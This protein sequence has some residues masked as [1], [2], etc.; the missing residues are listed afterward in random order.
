MLTW[1]NDNARDGQN[2]NETILTTSN[3]NQTLFG[4]KFSYSVDGQLYAQPLYV[5][6][7]KISG[8][9]H[10]VVY[11]A[12]ENDSVYAFDADGTVTT[13]LWKTNFLSTGT[14]TV[15]S[16]ELGCGLISPNIGITGTPVIDPRTNTLYVVAATRKSGSDSL[17]LHALDITTG[18]D[19]FGGP[20][21]ISANVSG[22]SFA[23]SH[24][25]QRPGLLLVNGT[26]YISFGSHCDIPTYH[27]WLLAYS[28]A[29][30]TQTAAFLVTPKG[31]DGAIWNGGAG[32]S[33][34]SSGNVYVTTGNGTFD[35][36]KSG[37][38]YGDSFLKFNSTLSLLDYF[39]PF[40]QGTLNSTDL[41]VGSSGVVLPPD[42]T[43]A[44]PHIMISAGKEGRIYVVNRDSLGHFHAGGDSQI[45]Q[46]LPG[47]LPSGTWTTAAYW[48]GNVYYAASSN[49]LKQY[50]LT[51]GLLSSAPVHT[52]AETFVQPGA[53]PSVSSNGTINGIIWLID[54]V[55][56]S[57]VLR[58]YD[59]TN[60]SN[61]LFDSGG[62]VTSPAVKFAPPTIAN[63][64][65][66]VGTQTQLVV[67]GL[68]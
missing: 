49:V 4:V 29:T 25:L 56:S 3:V 26:L 34:D 62:A 1:H 51:G 47:A 30:L 67:F 60:V 28:A 5:P 19:K 33:A 57:A 8:V 16:S 40:N 65:V 38:D 46:S 45:I 53:T 6:N 35:A 58:A 48:N 22:V 14:T 52:S 41:D 17:K 13:P 55:Q 59:A 15:L 27:G 37:K 54:L 36:N 23:A 21:T 39:T 7:V 2:L 11:V 12:T 42:Q 64:K 63:G 10:N 68:L 50:T 32:P 18:K 20:V 24:Q 9:T 44:H 61:K 31:S 66:Y 43:G